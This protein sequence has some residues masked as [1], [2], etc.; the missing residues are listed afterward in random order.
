MCLVT[1]WKKPRI[2]KKDIICYKL[3]RED[4][5]SL[6]YWFHWTVGK[7]YRNKLIKNNSKDIKIGFHAA[8]SLK[9]AIKYGTFFGYEGIYKFK[10]PAGSQYFK[11][12][13]GL[14]VANQMMLVSE[15]NLNS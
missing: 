10:I 2:A 12:S 8:L 3:L 14:I 6:C 4:F 15:K 11:D 13:T 1:K 5:T 7:V 9:R